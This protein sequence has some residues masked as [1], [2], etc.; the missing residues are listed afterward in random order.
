M[1]TLTI[2]ALRKKI[3]TVVD[4]VIKTGVP[5]TFIK[6]GQVLKISMKKKPDKLANL[7]KRKIFNDDPESLINLKLWEWHEPKNL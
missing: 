6:D 2:T 5:A 7:K 4:K 1:S 3:Y